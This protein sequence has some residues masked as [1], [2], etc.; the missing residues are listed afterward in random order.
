MIFSMDSCLGIAESWPY[1]CIGMSLMN[2][3]EGTRVP[4]I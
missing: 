1:V 4:H 2:L 3:W